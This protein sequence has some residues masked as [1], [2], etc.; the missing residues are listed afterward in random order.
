MDQRAVKKILADT[1]YIRVS[2]TA[3]EARCAEY[4]LDRCGQ[5][6]L[7]ARLEHFP[8]NVYTAEAERLT[9]AGRDIPCRSYW[10]CADADVSAP[11]I[12]LDSFDP[13]GLK[14]CRDRIVLLDG[15]MTPERWDLLADHGALGFITYGGAPHLP[16]RDIDRK[17]L[18]FEPRRPAP[19]VHIHACDA[20]RL[21]DLS[22]KPAHIA[23][24]QTVSVGQS[25]NV[26]LDLP[27]QMDET[28]TVCAH[29]DSTPLSPGAYD[30]MS[31]CI[32]LLY[33]AEYFAA[34]PHRRGIRLLWCGSEEPGLVGSLYHCSHN[35]A[36]MARTILNINLDMLGCAM[37]EFTAFSCANEEL[38]EFMR[39]F[40]RRRRFPGAVRCA[41]R[42][43]DSNSF[44][45]YGVPAVSFARYAPAGMAPIH[46]RCDTAAVVSPARLLKEAGLIAAFTAYMADTE[47]FPFPLAVCDKI[48]GDVETY[49]KYRPRPVRGDG[50]GAK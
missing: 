49:M 27:G 17:W 25:R 19:I 1:A 47:E 34:R 31:S 14:R 37:G 50:G 30:N 44:V 2:G 11:L 12:Y 3:E 43:S 29:Y 28:V 16:D 4:I 5:L 15:A 40:L 33:L 45:R 48:R 46:T 21:A 13:A 39:A 10:G 8:V 38:G 18:D 41:I 36:D 20:A 6:G 23:L 9:V 26:I 7:H 42:S 35:S 24:T 32:V 22:G